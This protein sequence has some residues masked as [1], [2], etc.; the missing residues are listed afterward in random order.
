MNLSSWNNIYTVFDP[1][2][3]QLGPIGIHW[4]G[5]MYMSALMTAFWVAKKL[6]KQ[7]GLPLTE[8]NLDDFALWEMIGV[9]MG[10]R[11]GY[12]LFYDPH[13][14]WYLSHPW[15]IF[16]PFM[17]G[18]FVGIR[19]FS[20]HGGLIG[21][22]VA[23]VAFTKL[24]KLPFWVL[25]DLSAIAAAAGYTFGR[26]GNFLNQELFGRAT[27]VPWGIYVDGVLRHPSQLY[28]AFAEG[29][30][31]F[32]VLWFARRYKKFDGELACY[33]GVL[34]GVGRIVCEQFREPDAQLGFLMFGATMGQILSFAII[35]ASGVGYV[36]LSKRRSF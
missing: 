5:I 32:I 11:L 3:L 24:R 31:V 28:E 33:Y 26:I 15:E 16:N 34:Y 9:I 12:I 29:L 8:E 1:V 21:F 14:S 25:L 13:T 18:S 4:Y 20:Y 10:A 6:I 36:I 35:I 2:A 22:L 19:G 27:D 23:L 17:N 30:V 7:D